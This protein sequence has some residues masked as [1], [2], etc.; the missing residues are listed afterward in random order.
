[1]T[2]VNDNV[3]AIS[4]QQSSSRCSVTE[5]TGAQE[6]VRKLTQAISFQQ[7]FEMKG[8]NQGESKHGVFIRVW[9]TLAATTW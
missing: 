1:M 5:V 6:S 2:N 7:N 9:D 4:S 8:I 3:T